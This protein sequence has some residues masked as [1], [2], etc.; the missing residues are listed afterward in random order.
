[1]QPERGPAAK[2]RGHAGAARAPFV[3]RET[4]LERLAVALDG[5]GDG[6]GSILLV[7]GEPGI[8]KSRLADET[9]RRARADGTRVLWGRCWEAGGAPA[10]WPWIQCLRAYVRDADRETLAAQVPPQRA[11][12][13]QIVPEVR[14]LVPDLPE[15]PAVDPETSRFRLFDATTAFLA[16]IA[17]HGP[18]L[19]ILDDL[20]AADAPSLLLLRFLASAISS[21]GI[22]VVGTYRDVGVPPGSPLFEAIAELDRSPLTERLLLG[23]LTE[24]D[25]ARLIE[26]AG[27]QSAPEL[28]ATV[29]RET[30]GN[31]LFVGEVVRL[32][33]AEGALRDGV[34][35]ARVPIPD[36]VRDVIVRRLAHLAER[37]REILVL[38]S[39]VGREFSIEIVRRLGEAS[40]AEVLQALDEAAEARIVIDAPSGLG[41]LRFSHALVRDALYDGIPPVRRYDLHARAADALEAL[42]AEDLQPH[43]TEIAHHAFAAAPSGAVRRAV[44]LARRAGDRAARLVAYEEAVRLYGMALEAA[45]LEPEPDRGLRLQVL[46]ALGD[47]RMKAGDDDGARATFLDAADVARELNDPAALAEAALG[48]GGRF[49][50]VRAGSDPHLIPLLEEALATLPPDDSPLRVRLLARLAG[51]I[52]I[53]S[54]PELWAARSAEAVEMARRLGDK[55]SLAYA[56]PSRYA[57]IWGPDN[58]EELRDIA[59]E[60]LRVARELRDPERELESQL[61]RHTAYLI[62]GDIGAARAAL[63]AADLLAEDLKQVIHRWYVAS[64]RT[65]AALFEGQLD[66]AERMI[67]DTRR[68]GER[69][70]HLDPSVAYR[71]Q[72]FQLRLEQGRVDEMEPLLRRS[73]DEYPW[74]PL[75]RC[76]LAYLQAAVGR[77]REARATFEEIVRDGFALVPRDIQW[78][79]AMSLLAEPAAFLGDA[80]RAAELH[81]LLVPFADLNVLFAPEITTGAVA[82]PAAVAAAAAGRHE[83]AE[84]LY[85]VAIQRNAAMGARPAVVRSRLGLARLLLD[86]GAP[87]DRARA[88]RLAADA[89]E[90]AQAMTAPA[91]HRAVDELQA[92]LGGASAGSVTPAFRR[93]GESWTLAFDDRSVRLRDSKGLRYLH[94]LLSVPGREIPALELGAAPSGGPSGHEEGLR[95]DGGH[96]GQLLDDRARR[97]YAQRI[98]DLEEDAEEAAR[99]GDAERA[100]RAREELE[101][102]AGE[103]ASAY[104]L[105]GRAR[106]ASDT[107][108][109]ARKAVTN[110]IRDALRRIRE[111]HPSLARHLE[112]SIRTGTFC[113]Y[114][115]DPPVAWSL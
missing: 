43:L 108:E 96:A 30:E 73:I 100:A 40:T 49:V 94:A 113:A 102:V 56:L 51:A 59:E 55:P 93:E 67:E 31:P 101:F 53:D 77:E 16:E 65:I 62:L 50:W 106:R 109:R 57:A 95:T 14:A 88:V 19:L 92:M 90:E 36:T 115:P 24:E 10:Y 68:L 79:Y 99:L 83:E 26:A 22:V 38:A 58:T 74:Y 21:S 104:G 32:L 66:D 29:R 37:T 7:S 86:R 52:R 20:H 107:G 111:A 60:S 25:V 89:G 45:A 98:R 28:A 39:V 17:R 48:Y 63:D 81:E 27:G 76:A 72:L 75:F 18:L 3:G 71:L 70:Q 105:G 82:R 15:P 64:Y 9:A 33:F 91:L 69:A 41:R 112:R 103:L 2:R 42:H 78:L 12:L 97:E 47:A 87:E 84:R 61:I 4:E 1:V 54:S 110:R 85:E 35:A 8:G 34:G 5:A 80:D 13:T 114:D 6:Q 11:D 46:L 23:G 44:D